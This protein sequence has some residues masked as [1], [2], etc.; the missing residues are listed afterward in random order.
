MTAF[1]DRIAQQLQELGIDASYSETRGL[2][3]CE[4]PPEVV[5]VGLDIFGRPRHLE[6]AAARQWRAMREAAKRDEVELLLVSAFRSVDYQRA[7]FDRKLGQGATLDEILRVNAAPGYS[8][9]HTGRAVDIA[10]RGCPP[11]TA[12]FDTTAA[13]DWLTRHAGRFD[14]VMTY[15][16]DNPYGMVYEPWHWAMRG[17]VEEGP[18]H[19]AS[20]ETGTVDPWS[21]PPR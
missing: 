9:H 10:T 2:P 18:R 14:F 21:T 13:F 15:P 1:A 6:P 12:A 16:R 7:I 17:G 8:E 5:L 19:E 11:L 20:L 3:L 4:E